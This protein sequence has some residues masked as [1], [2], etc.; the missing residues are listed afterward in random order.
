MKKIAVINA[1]TD[2]GVNV[3]GASLGAEIL[4]KDLNFSN[5]SHRYTLRD[6]NH[7]EEIN[8]NVEN[9][10]RMEINDFVQEF[11][12]LL[13]SMH[14]LH[15]EENMSDEEVKS[16]NKKMHDL[17]LSVKALDSKNEKRNLPSINEFNK[18]LYK[19]VGQAINDGDFPL[20]VGGD[21][22]IAIASSLASIRKHKNLGI[23]WFDSHADYNTYPTSVTGNLHGLPLAVAT[24]YEKNML[25]D[26]HE[27]PF[28]DPKHTVIVGG[29]DIDPWEWE[30]IIDAGV[31][32]F[33]TKDIQKYGTTEICKKAFEIASN[34]TNGVHISFDLD[35][36]DPEVAPGVSV[37]A[38]NGINLKETYELVDEIVKYSNII[39]SADLVEY[40]PVFDKN[41]M[42]AHLAKEIL[43]KWI[44]NF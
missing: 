25:A 15:F 34:G 31:T 28:Y 6:N 2:L 17:A 19:V 10:N 11:N 3:N 18:E 20:T 32:V 42:T 36:I 33:S 9:T 22:I 40:N 14:K 39:K 27:G 26:F 35:L 12:Y 43:K 5:I 29:R 38:K 24:N 7:K 44:E 30:N 16:Y 23:I 13:L 4:T 1:C 8:L 37:P 41:D 21:H